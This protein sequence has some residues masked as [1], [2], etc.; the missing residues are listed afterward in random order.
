MFSA[1]L[2]ILS[3]LLCWHTILC[4]ST[5]SG[6]LLTTKA[7]CCISDQACFKTVL[8][9]CLPSSSSYRTEGGVAFLFYC[10]PQ[11]NYRPTKQHFSMFSGCARRVQ[12]AGEAHL[13]TAYISHKHTALNAFNVGLNMHNIFRLR[14]K[15]T[16]SALLC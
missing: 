11:P 9:P 12:R 13:L 3:W 2:L 8:Q 1:F 7:L 15:R 4:H 16:R 10:T 6:A 14:S 5:T